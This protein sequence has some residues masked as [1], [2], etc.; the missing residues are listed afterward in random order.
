[1]RRWA[2]GAWFLR[3]LPAHAWASSHLHRF[4]AAIHSTRVCCCHHRG[5]DDDGGGGEKHSH[6][7]MHARDMS[8]ASGDAGNDE[9]NGE[10]R[11]GTPSSLSPPPVVISFPTTH[12]S[13]T[14]ND[15][16]HMIAERQ[17][18]ASE[19]AKGRKRRSGTPPTKSGCALLVDYFTSAAAARPAGRQRP[20]GRQVAGSGDGSVG[21]ASAAVVTSTLLEKLRRNVLRKRLDWQ[22]MPSRY[23]LVMRLPVWRQR[24][25]WSARFLPSSALPLPSGGSVTDTFV[26][27]APTGS[28]KS[29]LVPLFLLDCHWTRLLERIDASSGR[30]HSDRPRVRDGATSVPP[31]LPFFVTGS[32]REFVAE[33]GAS[34]RLCIVVSQPTRLA[35][36][37]LA[38]FT[39]AILLSSTT[40]T[41]SSPPDDVAQVGGRVGYAVGGDK[42][43]S[44]AT[45]IIYATPGY[46]LNAVLH[47]GGLLAP[48]TLIID[49]AHCRDME[50]DLL[51]AWAKQ[52]L[53][54]KGERQLQLRQLVL[55]S[56]TLPVEEMVAL[57]TSRLHAIKAETPS[58]ENVAAFSP[59]IL[60]VDA[61]ERQQTGCGDAANVAIST[62]PYCVEEYFIDDLSDTIGAS[63]VLCGSIEKNPLLE[64]PARRVVASLGHFFS[65]TRFGADVHTP[66]ARVLAQF[67]LF[68]LQSFAVKSSSSGVGDQRKPRPLQSS[69]SVPDQ[70][71]ESIL[72]FLP[73]FAEIS[74]VLQSLEMLCRAVSVEVGPDSP[75]TLTCGV[76][77]GGTSS[78][79]G[80]VTFLRYEQWC[81]SVALLHATAIGSPQQQLHDSAGPFPYRIILATTVAESSVTIP[82]VRCVVDSCLER[83]FF[84]DPLTGVMLRSTALASA[85]SLRQRGGRTGRTC[86]GAVIHLAPRR[87]FLQPEKTKTARQIEMP[88][89]AAGGLSSLRRGTLSG[90]VAPAQTLPESLTSNAAAV[91]LR[92]KYLFPLLPSA[93]VQN[94]P[95]PP[96][97][98][99]IARGVEQLMEL[100][101]LQL[102][103]SGDGGSV[104]DAGASSD[105]KC[106]T[107]ETE[108][109]HAV[110]CR[111]DHATL[112]AMG[113]FVAYLPL[114]HEQALLIYYALQFACIEEALIIACAMTVPSLLMFPRMT[115]QDDQS[116]AG[117]PAMQYLYSLEIQRELAGVLKAGAAKSS[118][119]ER[120]DCHLSEPLLLCSLLREW[121]ACNNSNDV[122][123]FH[124]KY[125]VNR[126]AIRLVDDCVAQCASR[127]YHLV[128]VD[129]KAQDGTEGLYGEHDTAV[130]RPST[131]AVEQLITSA[132]P[133]SY[134]AL[135]AGSLQRLHRCAME[136]ATHRFS[137]RVA[138]MTHW[139]PHDEQLIRLL[140]PSARVGDG[141][142][143]KRKWGENHKDGLTM[144]FGAVQHRLSAAF[145]AAFARNTMRGE[146]GSHRV[147]HRRL[148]R[149]LGVLQED[150]DSTCSFSIELHTQQQQV[151]LTRAAPYDRMTLEELHRVLAPY[152]AGTHLRQL[153]LFVGGRSAV[154]CFGVNE[155]KEREKEKGAAAQQEKQKQKDELLLV[156]HVLPFEGMAKTNS[157]AVTLA[158][159][160]ISLL[161]S[162]QSALT[163]LTVLLPPSTT[164]NESNKRSNDNIS[165]INSNGNN[166]NGGSNEEKDPGETPACPVSIKTASTATSSVYR[167]I[168]FDSVNE[169]EEPANVC[170]TWNDSYGHKCSLLLSDVRRAGYEELFP[171]P[172]VTAL[173]AASA[174][175]EAAVVFHGDECRTTSAGTFSNPSSCT[176]DQVRSKDEEDDDEETVTL[177]VQRV[178]YTRAVYWKVTLPTVR[179]VY[180]RR[181]LESASTSL[182][183]GEKTIPTPLPDGEC[184]YCWVCH[185][186]W[187]RKDAFLAHCRSVTHLTRLA[188]A[189]QHGMRHEWVEAFSSGTLSDLLLRQKDRDGSGMYMELRHCNVSPTSFMNAL[190]WQ[191]RRDEAVVTMPIAIAG[192]LLMHTT[193]V[194]ASTMPPHGGGTNL[195]ALHVW[196]LNTEN[197][198]CVFKKANNDMQAAT[199]LPPSVF[200]LAGYLAAASSGFDVALLMN[201]NH[202]RAYAVMLYD[203]GVWRL[204]APLTQT[205]LRSVLD[206]FAGKPWRGVPVTRED[207]EVN[208]DCKRD[209]TPAAAGDED[210][211]EAGDLHWC[212]V[213]DVCPQ[214]TY[215]GSGGV[216]DEKR[217]T[218]VQQRLQHLSIDN[219]PSAAEVVEGT[220]LL[221]LHEYQN[222][223][224]TVISF[225]DY[226]QRVVAKIDVWSAA[227]EKQ[228][229]STTNSF[230]RQLAWKRVETTTKAT[231]ERRGGAELLARFVASRYNQ[232]LESL[233]RDI[234]CQFL[235]PPGSLLQ[236]AT[237]QSASPTTGSGN[238]SLA[239]TVS[240]SATAMAAEGTTT[241]KLFLLPTVLPSYLPSPEFAALLRSHRRRMRH[242]SGNVLPVKKAEG[243]PAV[244]TGPQYKKQQQPLF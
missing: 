78:Q 153:E 12:S 187:M 217:A 115:A 159:I 48:T 160:G 55:M 39:A 152:L 244:T 201:K 59:H 67:L 9:K 146:D 210:D 194:P 104:N 169:D 154:A 61:E 73:G 99:A 156:P 191:P 1:M 71:P 30:L 44:P 227:Q 14:M 166:N 75:P 211:V 92:V 36:V 234:G 161:V 174:A 105:P 106:R 221:V 88:V 197:E 158:H 229:G 40:T 232:P 144:T 147:H 49:E 85:S 32:S 130:R 224:R 142:V 135:L 7:T 236:T 56:A 80:N 182:T 43:F 243:G 189:V 157:P 27:S 163:R 5:T 239:R 195:Q 21:A 33:F 82:N 228:Q 172:S 63:Q 164:P 137:R 113:E 108:D 208:D 216:S 94:L 175:P 47:K 207:H 141:N 165:G 222:S 202:T 116:Q 45:E 226:V 238:T 223:Q 117:T 129:A 178:V 138:T 134:R 100:G 110:L 184:H 237:K 133:R 11:Q 181:P 111:Y 132:F 240:F 127:L 136:H 205:R 103:T 91:L 41:D 126:S 37:E 102:D 209:V 17:G 53:R 24:F 120:S 149:N 183:T 109:L 81:F 38:K 25:A 121:Y 114:P 95:S 97:S 54:E 83:R 233:L 15:L 46:I 203:W 225:A 19:V 31:P 188:F 70:Q 118:G 167:G 8:E 2:C 170:V 57:F 76:S 123:A 64:A 139:Y 173:P 89:F 140:Q 26:C 18:P 6:E 34:S 198:A 190:Q 68:V 219:M 79:R 131:Q 93:L 20:Q 69:S 241:E 199:S 125:R 171:T 215:C 119:D 77:H 86:D 10:G 16:P 200:V 162:I 176:K 218:P 87:L 148:V 51:L 52:Q 168:C 23:P 50:T 204:P 124:T 98:D 84:T 235:T 143:R 155:T 145:V 74:L 4:D 150:A 96:S 28:G 213:S 60:L 29:S 180:K 3:R 128:A 179:F 62:Q 22:Q 186:A 90:F 220:I 212:V 42:C 112:T 101:L 206:V 72:V 58:G 107:G 66:Q 122:V 151:G 185:S 177:S 65:Y 231:A 196:V 35:C 193:A 214:C 242:T 192:S 230:S 13:S